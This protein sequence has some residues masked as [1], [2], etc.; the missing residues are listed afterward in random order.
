ME[1]ETLLNGL[2]FLLIALLVIT[3]AIAAVAFWF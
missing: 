2:T 3:S 1:K